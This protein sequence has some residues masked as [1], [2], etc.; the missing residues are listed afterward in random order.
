MANLQT[1]LPASLRIPSR[2][3]NPGN[4]TEDSRPY[5]IAGRRG[6]TPAVGKT[7]F[8]ALPKESEDARI[9]GATRSLDRRL[10]ALNLQG[11]PMSMSVKKTDMSVKMTD[12]TATRIA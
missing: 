12:M 9:T 4:L 2:R 6:R 11:S 10:L 3:A 8:I 7:A 5:L 1:H